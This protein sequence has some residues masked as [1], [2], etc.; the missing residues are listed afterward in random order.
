M[1]VSENR[2]AIA[3]KWAEAVTLVIPTHR[4]HHYLSR[5]LEYYR[6][7]P[8]LIVMDTTPGAYRGNTGNARYCHVPDLTYQEKVLA[9]LDLVQTPYAALCADD[10]FL[11]PK[12]IET[13][14]QFLELNPDY[15]S[16]QG[17]YIHFERFFGKFIF[18][19]DHTA[20]QFVVA[21]DDVELRFRSGFEK[22]MHTF[23]SVHRLQVL[24]ESFK[25]VL[26]CKLG[27]WIEFSVA[28][29]GHAQG[30][31][32]LL[33]VFY[34]ARELSQLSAGQTDEPLPQWIARNNE[35][36]CFWVETMVSSLIRL[37]MREEQ[38]RRLFWI[39]VGAYGSFYARR[40]DVRLNGWVWQWLRR[41]AR[42]SPKGL[43][44]VVSRFRRIVRRAGAMVDAIN[45]DRDVFYQDAIA[46]K[47]ILS[48]HEIAK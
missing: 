35:D 11:A 9:A 32:R 29:M 2:N 20:S 7:V 15:V 14:T 39:A 10:D 46:M 17:T 22:Y 45:V 42:S 28:L 8:Q 26:G 30:K 3:P 33:P 1:A 36:V 44:Q 12:G 31:H 4:R 5:A 19:P 27:N 21:E 16:C 38:A 41:Q 25:S 24:V 40:R 37:G 34:M 47:A 18:W 6:G 48:E 43:K 23:Y 13:C